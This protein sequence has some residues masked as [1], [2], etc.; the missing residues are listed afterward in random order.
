MVLINLQPTEALVRF[1]HGNR[2]LYGIHTKNKTSLQKMV[3]T[4]S[5]K[6]PIK[7]N[8]IFCQEG[9]EICMDSITIPSYS[10]VMDSFITN[11]MVCEKKKIQ[12]DYNE[13]SYD[14]ICEE[15][16]PG[17]KIICKTLSNKS[18]YLPA[19]PLFTIAK[20]KVMLQHFEGVPPDQAR[21]IFAGKQL[22]DD[23]TISYYNILDD[24]TIHIVLR[25][26]GGMYS[27]IS[28]RD[29]SYEI[30]PNAF[31]TI[32]ADLELELEEESSDKPS[33]K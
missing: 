1:A 14:K 27:E 17:F 6:Y 16:V 7:P 26:R 25:L 28:G 4:Y 21:L 3:T 29:G 19:S 20:L 11:I 31:F 18:I 15:I 24:S 30:L 13:I 23:K 10:D 2:S 9:K 8:E 22:E 33:D 5:S 32:E 12:L